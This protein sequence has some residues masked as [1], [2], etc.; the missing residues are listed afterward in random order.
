MQF[1]RD[2]HKISES[3]TWQAVRA[4]WCG[5]VHCTTA[6]P[7]SN[8]TTS[9]CGRPNTARA[10]SRWAWPRTACPKS[11]R[12]TA[13]GRRKSSRSRVA[14]HSIPSTTSRRTPSMSAKS[15][16]RTRRESAYHRTPS[17]SSPVTSLASLE[18]PGWR[19]LPRIRWRSSGRRRRVTEE[20]RLPTTSW[21]YVTY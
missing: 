17:P 7:R 3:R 9:S 11:Q 21:R 6:A 16:L 20:P 18:H 5:T 15:S 4:R 2:H 13:G 12:P 19:R 8:A 1:L 14:R 10:T